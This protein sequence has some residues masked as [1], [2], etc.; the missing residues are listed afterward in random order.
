MESSIPHYQSE[1]GA[2]TQGERCQVKSLCI[3]KQNHSN[4]CFMVCFFLVYYESYLDLG[5]EGSQLGPAAVA[6]PLAL[7]WHGGINN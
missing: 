6:V 1:E 4:V 5:L 3:T 7:P 2:C